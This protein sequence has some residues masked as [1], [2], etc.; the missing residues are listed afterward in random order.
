MTPFFL[1]LLAVDKKLD[2]SVNSTEKTNNVLRIS[3]KKKTVNCE[4][5]FV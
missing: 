4:V 2:I 3:Q 1:R 5:K